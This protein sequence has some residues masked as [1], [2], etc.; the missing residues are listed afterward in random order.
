MTKN[1]LFTV[2]EKLVKISRIYKVK[3]VL[4]GGIATSIFAR[5]RATYDIDAI[6][7]LPEEHLKDFLGSLQSN[8]FKFDTKQPIKSIQ[9]L[10]FITL[11]YP[12]YKTYVDFFIAKNKFQYEIL[13]RAKRV[14]LGKLILHVISPEDLILVKL[15]T[16]REKDLEDVRE[17][18]LENKSRLN[19]KYLKKWSA[20][21]NVGV[22]LKDELKSLRL[23]AKI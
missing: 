10:P 16:A 7:S 8:G 11:Y 18:I 13:K 3:M 4:M 21:L 6:I 9:G 2:L 22:F 1:I 23:Q 17:I 19:F 5:P 14:K 15:Q 20:L 12:V